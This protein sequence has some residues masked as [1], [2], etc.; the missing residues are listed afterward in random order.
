MVPVTPKLFF[1]LCEIAKCQ[2]LNDG[3]QLWPQISK[4]F[5][6]QFSKFLWISCRKFPG[7]LKKCQKFIC[8][9]SR[10]WEN[11]KNKVEPVLWD[12]RYT[13]LHNAHI[14][15]FRYKFDHIINYIKVQIVD[16]LCLLYSG[17]LLL[18]QWL[19]IWDTH[20]VHTRMEIKI[21]VETTILNVIKQ[22]EIEVN[23]VCCSKYN[24]K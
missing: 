21:F 18:Q 5:L 9:C 19:F 3:C 11:D 20:N 2:F 1:W 10:T 14:Q 16:L 15:N 12:T 23:F 22:L 4:L 13:Q 8:T 17:V 6:N 24:I 7:L